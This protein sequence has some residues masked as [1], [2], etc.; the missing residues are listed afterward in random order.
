MILFVWSRNTNKIICF[1]MKNIKNKFIKIC[2][3]CFPWKTNWFCLFDLEKQTKS[4]VFQ[5]K[6]SKTSSLRFV[7]DIFH[8]KQMILFVWSRKT[9]KIICFSMKNIKNK[10]FKICFWVSDQYLE[11]TMF[12]LLKTGILK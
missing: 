7:F 11:C 2:F 4:F 1:S 12:Y 5:W 3:W 8:G 9:N 10:F 6:T